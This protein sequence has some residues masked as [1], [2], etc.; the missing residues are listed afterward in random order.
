MKV[1]QPGSLKD[2]KEV[3]NQNQDAPAKHQF[4]W[5]DQVEN[6]RYLKESL[7]EEEVVVHIDFSE[8]FACKL[9]TEIQTFHFGGSKQ[10]ATIHTSDV[11]TSEGSQS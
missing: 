7:T 4:N 5:I 10:Q 9:A 6:C 8:N 2:V 1:A 3:F 11:Y